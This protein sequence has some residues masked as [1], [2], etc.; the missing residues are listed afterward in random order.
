[1]RINIF[2]LGACTVLILGCSNPQ[3]KQTDPASP[4]GA[5]AQQLVTPS[6]ATQSGQMAT[7]AKVEVQKNELACKRDQETRTLKVE[8]SQSKGCK[9]FYSNYSS[10]DAIAWSH[11]GNIHCEQVR[12]RIRGKLEEA[13]F[14]CFV[15]QTQ[16]KDNKTEA[17]KAKN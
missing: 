3:K 16:T 8:G 13:G 1:M 9:L 7:P 14:K 5:P 2:L 11:M 10:K 15:E 12:D 4:T 17:A 6:T